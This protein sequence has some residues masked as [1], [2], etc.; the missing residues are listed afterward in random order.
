M[1]APVAMMRLVPMNPANSGFI[2]EIADD[3]L[4]LKSGEDAVMVAVL[5]TV[6]MSTGLLSS[7]S[8]M[9]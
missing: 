6:C 3:P 8:T 1:R 9:P 5:V 4:T 2:V 7:P